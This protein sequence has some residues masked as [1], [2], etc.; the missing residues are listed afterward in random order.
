MAGDWIKMEVSTPDKPEVLAIAAR[1]G[2]DDPDYVVGKLFRVWRWFDQHTTDGNADGVTTALLDRIA[3]VSGFAEAMANVGWLD[4]SEAGISL[5]RFEKHCGRTAKERAQT[6]KRVANFKS[7]GGGNGPSNGG[8]NAAT[9]T[10]ALPREDKRKDKRR[11]KEKPTPTPPSRS[12]RVQSDAGFERFWSAYPRRRNRGQAEKAW[13][14]LK[15]DAELLDRILQAVEVAKRR[16]D[17]RKDDGRFVPYPATWLNA[18]GWEDDPGPPAETGDWWLALG[19]GSEQS[20][21]AAR[22]KVAA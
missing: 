14:K 12:G 2:W 5:P 17:W 19:F 22:E 9:V 3:G 15:P 11:E 13:A 20:A 18:K 4:A 21:L 6:A 16:D 1:M 10:E 7:N 8:G